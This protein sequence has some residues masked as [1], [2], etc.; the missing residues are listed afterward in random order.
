MASNLVFN[1]NNATNIIFY[2]LVW[3]Y[4]GLIL[5][6]SEKVNWAYGQQY[7][8]FLYNSHIVFILFIFNN[9]MC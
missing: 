8:N 4:F 2:L 1:T 7:A 5:Q 3:L 6:P 9:S